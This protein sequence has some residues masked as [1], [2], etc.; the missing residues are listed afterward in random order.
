MFDDKPSPNV[1]FKPKHQTIFVIYN[2][3]FFGGKLLYNVETI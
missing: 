1:T 2:F 3:N